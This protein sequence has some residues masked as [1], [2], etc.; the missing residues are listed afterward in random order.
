MDKITA[1]NIKDFIKQIK[2]AISTMQKEKDEIWQE[3]Y[4][5]NNYPKTQDAIQSAIESC[6]EEI[7][8]L[9]RWK[10]N[11]LNEYGMEK[12]NQEMQYYKKR[13]SYLQNPA[14][15]EIKIE[16][17][18]GKKETLDNTL[19]SLKNDLDSCNK[20]LVDLAVS[21]V[22]QD[23]SS[24][25]RIV[26]GWIATRESK[27][28][29][30]SS[31][32]E[33]D[34][35]TI[36]LID[37]L[38]SDVFFHKNCYIDAEAHLLYNSKQRFVEDCE[39]LIVLLKGEK[40]LKK[41]IE[42]STKYGEP[43]LLELIE[44]IKKVDIN[45]KEKIQKII[46]AYKDNFKELSIFQDSIIR[47]R[48]SKNIPQELMNEFFGE[49]NIDTRS[50]LFITYGGYWN[51]KI[52]GK[53]EFISFVNNFI[54]ENKDTKQEEY[55]ELLNF[56]NKFELSELT[57]DELYLMYEKMSEVTQIKISIPLHEMKLDDRYRL[58]SNGLAD[59][60]KNAQQRIDNNQYQISRLKSQIEGFRQ[61]GKRETIL[62]MLSRPIHNFD[63][64]RQVTLLKSDIVPIDPKASELLLK[65]D[66]CFRSY[67]NVIEGQESLKK[68]IDSVKQEEW[69]PLVEEIFNDESGFNVQTS[70]DSELKFIRQH[71][72]L[73][74][75][76]EEIQIGGS[77]R[78]KL[79]TNPDIYGT[80]QD[81]RHNVSFYESEVSRIEAKNPEDDEKYLEKQKELEELETNY[82][83]K[84][85]R[86]VYDNGKGDWSRGKVSKFLFRV[87]K[88]KQYKKNCQKYDET[89]ETIQKQASDRLQELNQQLAEA[90]AHLKEA[91][92]K[93]KSYE[94]ELGE[95]RMHSIELMEQYNNLPIDVRSR[96]IPE[97]IQNMSTYQQ[98]PPVIDKIKKDY[99]T[100]LKELLKIKN[101]PQDV[102]DKIN[103][104]LENDEIVPIENTIQ[105]NMQYY[106]T[107]NKGY[108][109]TS[110][111]IL[112]E[113]LLA[114]E[115]DISMP[116]ED[117]IETIQGR[118]K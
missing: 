16:E 44:Q 71:Q 90:K 98:Y 13:L 22:L 109:R 6:N 55:K 51:T 20:I 115:V 75:A 114:G 45:D 4:T 40:S 74:F 105:E 2:E 78:S 9:E 70:Y 12:Y 23:E 46:D 8:S 116:Q 93:L 36:R 108:S 29:K 91:Q 42:L 26:D 100:S 35:R 1:E 79:F 18:N 81:R 54:N 73:G 47:A 61:K 111:E 48:E 33:T 59:D 101:L 85:D 104:I 112:K 103:A 69:Y 3:L 41:L 62:D 52:I 7:E 10:E 39:K 19:E 43:E 37:E 83:Q 50:T 117:A 11:G 17:L 88:R 84:K 89:I 99:I 77:P 38:N 64:P 24:M 15:L 34:K 57:E 87:F 68:Q 30:L 31:E 28:S 65:I 21:T 113:R 94:Q 80:L 92:E 32:I 110:D 58:L 97:Y 49:T 66:S 86:I 76:S 60:R 106:G 96:V 102:I 25:K 82:D 72:Y 5:L 107:V 56:L 14:K 27:I 67:S 118:R 53:E 95:P 63:S